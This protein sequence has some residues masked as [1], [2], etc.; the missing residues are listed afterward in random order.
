MSMTPPTTAPHTHGRTPPRC[1]HCGVV[2]D[3]LR[4]RTQ[5]V[6][7]QPACLQR[8]DAAR[9]RQQR[10]Q[11]ADALRGSQVDTLGAGRA[12]TLPVV[13]ISAFETPLVDLPAAARDAHLAYLM[14]IATDPG[15]AQSPAAAPA[16][17]AA[18]P[19]R[20][21]S[22]LCG[23]CGG[24]CC[25]YGGESD[26][27]LKPGHLR[28]WQDDHPGRTLQDAAAAYA[29]RLPQRHVAGSCPYHGEHGCTLDR[30]MRSDVCNR[31]ACDGLREL[32]TLNAK[33]P[34][35]D[36]L[37]VMHQRLQLS[38]LALAAADGVQPL[39]PPAAPAD[40]P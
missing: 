32:Q 1:R 34:R 10:E 38:A 36:W 24:R 23:W 4:A 9:Q 35:D 2:L 33:Q 19:Q 13:W 21:E 3:A 5:P 15:T 12:A 18:P 22:Q 17:D 30:T 37:F 31:Y 20:P 11:L 27:Y 39:V 8:E 28:R 26:A 25:R 29:E 6:C 40:S 7:P 14:Q 16:P